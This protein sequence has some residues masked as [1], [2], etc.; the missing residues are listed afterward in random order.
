MTPCYYRIPCDV[1]IQ[2]VLPLLHTTT[3]W[4]TFCVLDSKVRQHMVL[5]RLAEHLIRRDFADMSLS[6]KKD[7]YTA[8]LQS[9]VQMHVLTPLKRASITPH[10][11]LYVA[12]GLLARVAS[13]DWWQHTVAKVS[14]KP[15][16]TRTSAFWK[17]L[18]SCYRSGN[19]VG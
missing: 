11:A 15:L 4:C 10:D 6:R 7:N 8:V 13:N 18:T 14:R 16:C 9:F 1:W 3:A 19:R 12:T 5:R 17:V 2:H